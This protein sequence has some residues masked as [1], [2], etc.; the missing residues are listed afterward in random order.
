MSSAGRMTANKIVELVQQGRGTLGHGT[1]GVIAFPFC[2]SDPVGGFQFT[3][4][5]MSRANSSTMDF[6]VARL[7][8]RDRDRGRPRRR[9]A[10]VIRRHAASVFKPKVLAGS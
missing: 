1:S 8:S 10:E 3:P 4:P 7:R 9:N 5:A 2:S 6:V